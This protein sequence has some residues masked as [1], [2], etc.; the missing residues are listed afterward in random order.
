MP[1]RALVFDVGQTGVYLYHNGPDRKLFMDSRLEIPS[2]ET[3]RTYISLEQWLQHGDARWTEAVRRMGDPLILIA[4][5]ENADAVATLL[6]DRGWRC[7][8]F[9]PV[10]AVFLPDHDSQ[11]KSV[12]P[13][14][15]FAARYFDW[16]S[17]GKIDPV[18][19]LV[20]AKAFSEIGGQMA[21]RSGVSLAALALA[22][23][24]NATRPKFA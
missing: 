19:S 13:T 4:H 3:F 12:Y 20:E 11:L 5:E 23:A 14:V 2:L 16:P 24:G 9:D 15:D 18:A 22:L 21:R 6:A 1:D 10:A 7:V 17:G 8:W